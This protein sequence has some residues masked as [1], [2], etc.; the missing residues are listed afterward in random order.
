LS[1]GR[2]QHVGNILLR[3]AHF[4]RVISRLISGERDLRGQSHQVDFVAALDHAASRSY[5]SRADE[6][7][8]GRGFPQA[9]AKDKLYR[10]LNADDAGRDS[11]IAEALCNTGV[12][13]LVFLPDADVWLGAVWCLRDLL[14]SSAFLECGRNVERFAF[15]GE[16]HGK[17]A[18]STFPADAGEISQGCARGDKEGGQVV[19]EHQAAGLF[20][21]RGALF[22]GDGL[23]LCFERLKSGDGGRERLIVWGGVGQRGQ[24]YTDAGSEG[25]GL[26]ETTA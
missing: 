26:Q 18:L 4:H 9:I 8:A 15:G 3:H 16:D 20:L 19:V 5:R 11:A 25:T 10:L 17:E 6:S 7:G 23:G 1:V 2:F 12:G 22:D 24:S 21:A 13:A 14:A